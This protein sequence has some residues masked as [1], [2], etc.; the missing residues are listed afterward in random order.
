MGAD[1][2]GLHSLSIVVALATALLMPVRARAAWGATVEQKV[3]GGPQLLQL[4][5]EDDYDWVAAW[6]CN[7]TGFTPR[8]PAPV[9]SPLASD[10]RMVTPVSQIMHADACWAYWDGSALGMQFTTQFLS[11]ADVGT[12]TIVCDGY[13]ASPTYCYASNPP[14]IPTCETSALATWAN[15]FTFT[16]DV[17]NNTPNI[18]VTHSPAPA[19]NATVTLDAVGSDPDGDA[20]SYHWQIL[21]HPPT[22][23]THLSSTTAKS[24]TIHFTSDHDIGHW[25]FQVDVDDATGERRTFTH[26][27]DVPN[28]PPSITINGATEINALDTIA[29]NATPTTDVDGGNLGIVWDIVSSPPTS[30]HG[31]QS[32]FGTGPTFP[33]IVTTEQDIGTWTIRATATDNE[34]A[35]DTKEATVTVKNVPPEINL[36][37]ASQIEVGD[38]IHA[39]TTILDDQDGGSL[40]F[41]WDLIQ[42]PQSA[43]IPI[44]DGLFTGSSI[45]IPTTYD[46]AGTWVFELTA[47]DN[48]G[49]SVTQDYTVLV[50]APPEADIQ[51]SSATATPGA[52]PPV[53]GIGDFPLVLDASGSVDPDSPCPSDPD[54]CHDTAGQPV[55]ISPGISGYQWSLVDEPL[56][57][58]GILP[59]GRVDEVFG[60]DGSSPTVTFDHWLDLAPGQYTF[61]VE[62]WDGE[63]NSDT[64]LQ[65]VVVLDVNSNPIAVVSPPARYTT[66]PSGTAPTDITLSAASSFDLDNVLAGDTPGPG[67]G[68]VDYQ[69]AVEAPPGCAPPALPSGAGAA[70]VTLYSAGDP[71]DP[72]CQGRWT[73]TATVGDDDTPQKHG[74]AETTVV[75]GNCPQPLCIDAPTTALPDVVDFSDQTDV[76]IYYHLD[77]AIYT[78]PSLAYGLFAELDIYDEHD[79]STPFHTDFDP[80]V[81]ASDRG[82]FLVFNWNGYGDTFLRP[83]SGPYDV[84]ITVLDYGFSTTPFTATQPASIEIAVADPQVLPT[85]DRYARFGDLDDGSTQLH[86]NYQINGGVTVDTLH[87]KIFDAA[88]T[89]LLDQAVPGAVTPAGTV[90]WDGKIAGVTLA[91]GDYTFQLDA[92]R[93]SASLGT[94][95]PY[96]FTVYKLGVKPHAGAVPAQGLAV[97]VND[98]DDDQNGSPDVGQ[99]PAP[100]AE[101]DLVQLDL[102]FEPATLAGTLGSAPTA[103]PPASRSGRRP[104]RAPRSPCPRATTPRRARRRPRSGSR[105]PPL[106]PRRSAST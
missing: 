28:V 33:A 50:D 30:T 57:E 5:M 10:P 14:C 49:A 83:E 75:I 8:S 1:R 53:V 63:G 61:Q 45:D 86:F 104:P 87:F 74:S 27:F 13:E 51:V 81:L 25:E 90:T 52:D 94:S 97:F 95:P 58:V 66:T 39:E 91:P 67:V 71:I 40:T 88:H 73:F 11:L 60:I 19:W 2:P 106:A 59:L 56:E 70:E 12:W 54:R 102:V 3:K 76:S 16:I 99:N 7:V 36:V 79:L 44:Q 77:S 6:T 34:G 26:S 47:T 105:G 85:S 24:P 17:Y 15:P 4:I 103:P 64:A 38:T 43:G 18:T 65:R 42:V 46:D 68:I 20:L 80:N 101:N 82:S 98:D 55:V 89:E 78:D 72:T 32:H 41:S 23:T 96:T 22:S 21:H 100:A 9:I 69:W 48:E 29:L 35:T 93:G 84:A 62:V 37:G 31:P 92:R